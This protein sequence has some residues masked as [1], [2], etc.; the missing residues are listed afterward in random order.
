MSKS[1][2]SYLN[3]I[4]KGIEILVFRFREQGL[5]TTALWLR[6]RATDLLTGI[7]WIRFSQIQPDLY[8]GPQ[9]RRLGRHKLKRLGITASINMRIEFDDAA[10]GLDFEQY[11]HLPTVD[12]N[13]PALEQL[14]RGVEFIHRARKEGRKVYIH[15]TGGIGRAPT[16]AAAYLIDQGMK[17]EEAIA[18]IQ[19]VRPFINI[20]PEQMEQLRLYES[21]ARDS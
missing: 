8:I 2:S 10:H 7:P 11:C 5:R 20:V 21:G 14:K 9:Y 19:Q 17:L 3:L 18:A 6:I 13:A 1:P 12:D 15:C 4:R 16:M